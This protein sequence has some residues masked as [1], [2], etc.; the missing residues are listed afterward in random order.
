[1]ARITLKGKEY[2]YA[3]TFSAIA[4][5]LEMVGEDSAEGLAAFYKLPPSR[6]PAFITACVNE[7]L[8]EEGSE[9]RLTADEVATASIMEVGN[10]AAVLFQAMLPKSTGEEDKKK[11]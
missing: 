10:A 11:D 1:M 9:Q 6:Y 5:Y 4:S 7:G 8:K 2:P 3:V